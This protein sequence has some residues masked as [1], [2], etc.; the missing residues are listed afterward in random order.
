MMKIKAGEAVGVAVTVAR[1]GLAEMMAKHIKNEEPITL[2]MASF[3][4]SDIM[5]G[6]ILRKLD[7]DT[8]SRRATD[9]VVDHLSMGRVGLEVFKKY[10]ASR[11]YIMILAARACAISCMNAIHLAKTGEVTKGRKYQRATDLATAAFALCAA[12]GNKRLTHI[13]G[14]IASS[15]AIATAPANLKELGMKHESGIREL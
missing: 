7:L 2:D 14:A 10:P 9:G 3:I 15:I 12:T 4:V 8:P 13:S 5:D 11:T 1:Y 6:E